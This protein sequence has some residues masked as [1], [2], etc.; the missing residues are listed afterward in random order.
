MARPARPARMLSSLVLALVLCAAACSRPGEITNLECA[1]PPE[2]DAAWWSLDG[3][4]E[5]CGY[6]AVCWR[7]AAEE[8]RQVRDTHPQ[9]LL[10]HRVYVTR[11]LWAARTV[12]EGADLRRQ[13][14]SEYAELAAAYPSNPAYPYFLARIVE[15]RNAIRV[16]LAHA[17]QLDPG[18]PW[19]R[20]AWIRDLAF[21]PSEDDRRQMR[22]HLA[23]FVR[24]CPEESAEIL[25]LLGSVNDAESWH[26]YAGD[27]R[28]RITPSSALA[29]SLPDLWELEFRFAPPSEHAA[30]RER[31]RAD[32]VELARAEPR[33]REQ[34]AALRKGYAL[35]A[36]ETQAQVADD[37][38]LARFPCTAEATRIRLKRWKA[39]AANAPA[40][41]DA[42][43]ARA[44]A[45][46]AAVSA[47][48]ALPCPGEMLVWQYYLDDLLAWDSAPA[49]DVERVA[50]RLTQL[51]GTHASEML[52]DAYLKKGMRLERVAGLIEGA[53]ERSR[54][55][56]EMVRAAGIEGE[57]LKVYSQKQAY[58]RFQNQVLRAR[59]ALARRDAGSA[60]LALSRLVGILEENRKAAPDEDERMFASQEGL[61]WS[62]RAERA[63]LSGKEAEALAAYGSSLG[64]SPDDASVGRSARSVYARL[65]GSDAGFEAW[66]QTAVDSG[67]TA[68]ARP[69]KSVDRPLPD[70]TLSDLSGRK[71][72]AKD[73]AGKAVLINVWATWCG[74]C[75]QELPSVQKLY[76][77]IKNSRDVGVVTVS[78]DDNPGLIAPFL[79]KEKFTFPVLLAEAGGLFRWSPR[80]GIPMSYVIDRRGRIVREEF[81]FMGNG[82]A[83][84][85]E[86]ERALREAAAAP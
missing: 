55:D 33:T 53:E 47:A 74:P 28:R 41:D 59:L 52:A 38:W 15:N 61:L 26:A 11:T 36:D 46:G 69:A 21:Q 75:R 67:R 27:L 2:V 22:E 39:D 48:W 50:D 7:R 68:E 34:L 56:W 85:E 24:A 43:Q 82:D 9:E 78:V 5:R 80:G 12:P 84:L 86:T 35:T 1:R 71:W 3:L 20:Q 60:D 30:L 83:W 19:A 31:I 57:M 23:A 81:G 76:E 42:V 62:L 6:D 77:K 10:A 37:E 25:E 51:L 66:R 29:R 13:L 18:F 40:K 65:N 63:L 45:D 49:A 32:L 72:S 79:E 70:F 64:A 44:A 73:L 58:E 16:H 54:R 8:G 17:V 14:E 4:A